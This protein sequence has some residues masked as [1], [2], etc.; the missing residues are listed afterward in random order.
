MEEEK[1]LEAAETPAEPEAE[2][3]S[4]QWSAQLEAAI[5]SILNRKEFSYDPSAD[6]LYQQYKDSYV[7]QGRLAMMDTLGQAATLTG[8]YGNSYAQGAGQQAYERYLQGLTD[9]MPQLYQLALDRYDRENSRLA[10]QYTVLGDQESKDY[11][12]YQQ[13]L[14]RDQQAWENALKLYQLDVRT[15][16]VLEILGIP[17]ETSGGGGG[18]DEASPVRRS[19]TKKKEKTVEQVYREAKQ[20]GASARSLDS[21][22]KSAVA[23]NKISQGAAT[24]LRNKRW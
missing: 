18:G 14:D 4:S 16:E 13:D 15:P 1:K 12:R 6:A 17:V 10:Q 3:Y 8:G 22:L 9:K 5:G 23:D 21:Y 11:D 20:S 7:R 19:G 24:E 2:G